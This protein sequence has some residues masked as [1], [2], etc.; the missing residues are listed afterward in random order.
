MDLKTYL[1]KHSKKYED[2]AKELGVVQSAVTHWANGSRIPRRKEMSKIHEWSGGQVT[3][4][5]FYDFSG[6]N[7]A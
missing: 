1:E 6:G 3:P 2:A 5:D 7:A 4:N